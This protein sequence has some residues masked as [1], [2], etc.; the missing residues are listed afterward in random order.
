MSKKL[1]FSFEML[2]VNHC[3]KQTQQ[4]SFSSTLN[5][6]FQLF[7]LCSSFQSEF[8]WIDLFYFKLNLFILSMHHLIHPTLAIVH[9]QKVAGSRIMFYVYFCVTVRLHYVL[10]LKTCWGMAEPQPSQA[11]LRAGLQGQRGGTQWQRDLQA[12]CLRSQV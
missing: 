5:S 7:W 3:V 4:F 10:P 9:K 1:F 2:R 11:Q 8:I 12:C 6:G